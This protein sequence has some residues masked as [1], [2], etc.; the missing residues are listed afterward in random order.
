MAM[1]ALF[2]LDS[3]ILNFQMIILDTLLTILK[4]HLFCKLFSWY[5]IRLMRR[6][7]LSSFSAEQ[8]HKSMHISAKRDKNVTFKI[9]QHFFVLKRIT[10]RQVLMIS[11]AFPVRV[12][13]HMTDWLNK[14]LGCRDLSPKH[15]YLNCGQIWITGSGEWKWQTYKQEIVDTHA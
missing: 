15:E 13:I 14:F 7:L 8:A 1:F 2:R 9:L 12:V 6:D 4:V 11:L 3:K 5:I 10:L